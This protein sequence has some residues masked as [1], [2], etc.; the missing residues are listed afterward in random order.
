MDRTYVPALGYRFLTRLYDPL[1]RRTL[2]DAKLKSLLVDA[3]AVEAGMRVLDVGCGPGT[4]VTK[5]ARAI[6]TAEIIGLDGDPEILSIARKKAEEAGASVRFVE[7][8]ATDPPVE[9]ERG[10]FDRIVTSLLLHHLSPT[11]KERALRAMF[12][13]LRP[14]GRIVV[15]DWGEA[16]STVMRLAFLSIQMLDGFAN[17]ADHARGLLP[18]YVRRAGFEDVRE[19]YRERTIYGVVSFYEAVKRV[20]A[21]VNCRVRRP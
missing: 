15:A 4:L 21:A 20:T 1:V 13:L 8:L 16:R 9:L 19:T 3:L 11:D 17:T 10:S 2:K 12:D 5:L 18:G 7:G 14:G 6:P